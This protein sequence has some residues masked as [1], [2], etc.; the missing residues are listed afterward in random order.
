MI[1]SGM[2]FKLTGWS[3]LVELVHGDGE[4][5]QTETSDAFNSGWN[6]L[7]KNGHF[8][9]GELVKNEF[10]LGPHR[11]IVA[12]AYAQAGKDIGTY[13]LAMPR[14]LLPIIWQ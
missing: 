14:P 3:L 10:D 4:S 9:R 6:G 8:F 2:T 13:C 5:C 7:V 11:E 1:F 12:Y